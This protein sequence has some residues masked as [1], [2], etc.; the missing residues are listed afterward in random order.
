MAEYKPDKIEMWE[1]VDISSVPY[2]LTEEQLIPWL[3]FPSGWWKIFISSF[4]IT[5]TWNI[6]ISWVWFKPKLVKFELVHNSSWFWSWNMTETSQN[7]TSFYVGVSTTRCIDIYNNLWVLQ[8]RAVYVSMD[9][10]WFT[11][12][13]QNITPT[14]NVN[15]TA[16]W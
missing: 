8:A 5:S 13:V 14:L 4:N 6:S 16:F 1:S 9:N 10:D 11:I 12:N 2:W 3:H 15:F 7:S